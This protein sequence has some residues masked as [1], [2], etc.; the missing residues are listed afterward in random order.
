ML[1][2]AGSA[3]VCCT[4][5]LRSPFDHFRLMR[6]ESGRQEQTHHEFADATRSAHM[7]LVDLCVHPFERNIA[8]EAELMDVERDARSE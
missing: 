4:G 1:T 5:Q 6:I 3:S 8:R 2:L 7:V